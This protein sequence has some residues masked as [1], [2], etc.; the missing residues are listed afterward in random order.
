MR[1]LVTSLELIF[2]VFSI[3]VVRQDLVFLFN[4]MREGN[5]DLHRFGIILFDLQ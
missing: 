1:F 3:G 4:Q 5:G 2:S